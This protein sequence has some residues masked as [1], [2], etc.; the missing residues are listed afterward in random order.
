MI[1]TGRERSGG[2]GSAF[3]SRQDAQNGFSEAAES[4]ATEAYPCGT[5]QGDARPRT[6]QEAVFSILLRRRGQ[7][8]IRLSHGMGEVLFDVIP[9]GA[10]AI[11]LLVRKARVDLM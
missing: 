1:L 5:S 2:G 3:N 4:P 7:G 8:F 6:K 10:V 9:Q 11:E